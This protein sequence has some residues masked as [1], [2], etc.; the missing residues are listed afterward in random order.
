MKEVEKSE[1][2][3]EVKEDKVNTDRTNSLDY[4]VSEFKDR[5]I[6]LPKNLDKDQE[7]Q[8]HMQA[9]VRVIKEA[10]NGIKRADWVEH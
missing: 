6:K 4:M 10:A 1:K 7:F 3:W 5:S 9:P 2:Y 8:A